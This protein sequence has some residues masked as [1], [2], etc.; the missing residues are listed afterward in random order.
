MNKRPAMNASRR[1]F[2]QRSSA[3]LAAGIASPL[4]LNLAAISEASA[5]TATDYKA[6]VCIYLTGGNDQ[7]N[8]LVPY[9]TSSY[10][11][12]R[13]LRP[14]LAL[15]KTGDNLAATLLAPKF[16]NKLLDVNGVEHQY[17]L[18]PALL[19]LKSIF[20]AGSMAILL[21]VGTL[22]RPTTKTQYNNK[23]VLLPPRLFSHNDQA[24]FWQSL[25]PEGATSGWGGRMGD[26]L[27]NR[28]DQAAFTNINAADNAVFLSGNNT[29]QYKITTKSPTTPYL[30]GAV[31]LD[32]R[33]S[34]YRADTCLTALKQLIGEPR[35]HLFEKEHN[36]ITK[37]ALISGANLNDALVNVPNYIPQTI[38]RTSTSLDDQLNM[39]ARMIACADTLTVKRQV[40]FVSLGG[41]DMHDGL[42]DIQP[43]LLK[44]V[45]DAMADFHQVT[46]A[47]GVANQVTTF[48][49][50]DF[51]RTLVG[52]NDGSDH[53]W[54]SMH[55][56][57]GG[58]VNGSSYYG[59]AP[60]V[61]DNGPD[62]VGKGRLL[63]TTS[64]DQYAAT[65]GSWM[66]VSDTE[67]LNILPNLKNFDV[68]KRNLG[69]LMV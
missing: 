11:A 33:D 5:A 49:A 37:R 60:V 59:T 63:P 38:T 30:G 16:G 10:D 64:V 46:Q 41:F 27:A 22:I 2:L 34:L 42:P 44:K 66:G 23:L 24:S 31:L 57:M 47:M 6:L 17:A 18:A 68:N 53:G 58:A 32:T 50:S 20:D 13:R 40:F 65:L 14:T 39:V 7:S 45:A 4:I 55:F 19:P 15:S 52:N 9:D 21:N 69:F 26:L 51:G 12:Y 67:L 25:S 56:I 35:E 28:Y 1:A 8:T 61:A 36:I 54:G 48:T 29:S 62:D 43:L 3:L